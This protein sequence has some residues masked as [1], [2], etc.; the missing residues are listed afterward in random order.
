MFGDP[1]VLRKNLMILSL[2]LLIVSLSV[3]G[4]TKGYSHTKMLE[5]SYVTTG[6]VTKVSQGLFNNGFYKV[7]A[8]Y[9]YEG[10]EYKTSGYVYTLYEPG[11]NVEV[12]YDRWK[13]SRSYVGYAPAS[14][15]IY[16]SMAP[17]AVCSLSF[18]I[19]GGRR[20]GYT[21]RGFY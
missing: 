2:V 19:T 5:C 12:H 9:E 18:L 15:H 10:Q 21:T 16:I 14:R 4:I 8:T 1:D 7:N 3:M 6:T 11:Q 17:V 13:P 20:R